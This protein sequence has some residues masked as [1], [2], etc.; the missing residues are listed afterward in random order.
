MDEVMQVWMNSPGHRENILNPQ[1][2]MF[3]SAVSYSGSTPYYTQDF[4]TD[5]Q[6]ARNVPT[7][8]GSYPDMATPSQS[9]SGGG[10]NKG[11]SYG[12]GN[13]ASYGGN[14]DG[15]MMTSTGGSY[16][17]SQGGRRG[18]KRSRKSNGGS[19]GYGGRQGGSDY[20]GGDNTM[21]SND[22][23]WF[24]NQGFGQQPFGKRYGGFG[25]RDGM[26]FGNGGFDNMFGN[27]FGQNFPRFGN[28]GFGNRGFGGQFGN[29]FGGGFG[30]FY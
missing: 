26:S 17:G 9:S 13:E 10:G 16:G 4:G 25:D 19:L 6:A 15:Q 21:M 11:S 24:A 22:D 2:T 7:C 30:G 18:H 14:N 5:G 23:D 27:N 3:G 12:G 20:N 8:D 28:G 29:G 1:Y